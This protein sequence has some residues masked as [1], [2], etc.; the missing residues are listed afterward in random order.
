MVNKRFLFLLL[1]SF[2]MTGCHSDNESSEKAT[3]HKAIDITIAHINDTHAHLDP[4]ENSLSI[5]PTGQ[6]LFEFYAQL[7]GYPRLKAKL[8]QIRESAKANGENFLTLF[9]GDAFQG[10][11]Y[12]TKFRGEEE[13]RLLSEMGIDAAA[14][15]NHEFDLGNGPLNDYASR[16]NYPIV[17]A[18]LVKSS[19]EKLKDNENI[20]EYIVKS[21]NG[22]DVGIFGL[23]LDN[24]H[25][26]STPDEETQFLPMVDTAQR[27]VD[28][29]KSLGIN[30]IIMVTHIGL[31]P[32]QEVARAVN[33]I[34]LIVGG[35]SQTHM[36]DIKE[37]NEI[38]YTAHNQ[39]PSDD[40]TYAQLITNPDGVGKTCI[41]QAGEWAKGYGL[42]KI[43]LNES[44][45]LLACN[46]R[47]TLITGDDFTKKDRDIK[48]ALS[49]Q[50]QGMVTGFIEDHPA[51]EIVPED[52]GMRAIIDTEYK[53]KVIELES[54]IIANVPERLPHVRVPLSP[55]GAGLIDPLVAESLYE[56][57]K[58]LNT[59]VEITIQ[60]AGG[61]RADVEAGPL[62]VGYIVGTLLPFGNK[63]AVFDLKG[64]D[65][66]E[67][68]E[69]AV[70][71]A[72]GNGTGIAASSG[73]FP[74]V[75]HMQYT[76]DGSQQR[77]SRIADINVLDS[78]GN[79]NPLDDDKIYRVGAN[80]Y[81]AQGK[82]GFNGLL[83]RNE[84][85]DGGRYIDTGVAENEM[86]MDFV[87]ERKELKQL[88]YPTIKYY[89]P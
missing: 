3:Q 89:A 34:D 74:Y 6:Q 30:K 47:N 56:G 13:S 17:A 2:G 40:N 83:K 72:I 70:D 5:Q 42:V 59:G 20:Y 35:H 33:G 46:G 73:A 14:L 77:G 39:N 19:S 11:L 67:T 10:T 28:K 53:P 26:I 49:N 44:G 24:M 80:S 45:E 7:G 64:R 8:Q 65:V 29:L 36:G 60:N 79:W 50:E 27:M 48:I 88:S 62:S 32:D 76:Y 68:I 16:V 61:I 23:V 84:L 1:L 81:I 4:T 63:I 54:K 75:G 15:G 31:K 18:N 58:R 69:Y 82:D 25:S 38:G 87:E 43:S 71:Y 66:R 21:V 9:G 86:F 41:V 55:D 85:P 37:L 12:F 78:S 51:I 57:L 22:E 52:E